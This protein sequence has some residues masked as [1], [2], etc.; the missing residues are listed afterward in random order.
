MGAA[1]DWQA[2]LGERQAAAKTMNLKK[3]LANPFVLVA[4]GFVAGAI[5]FFAVAQ[6]MQA[7]SGAAEQAR[8]LSAA[9]SANA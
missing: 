7:D 3:K 6:P 2:L 8:A 9:K 4:Q 5:L 1:H